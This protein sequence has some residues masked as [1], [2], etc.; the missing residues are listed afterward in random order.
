[1]KIVNRETFLAMPAGTV[2][3][4]YAPF[5]FEAL[6]IKAQTL[7]GQDYCYQQIVCSLDAGNA[8]EWGDMLEDSRETGESLPMDFDC[9]SRDGC[10]DD[11]QLFAVFEH[12]DVAALIARLQEALAE[13]VGAEVKA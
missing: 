6:E 9:L 1:M 12:S 4:K 10:F 13:S 2:F 7:N 8:G 3:A 11:D 5:L